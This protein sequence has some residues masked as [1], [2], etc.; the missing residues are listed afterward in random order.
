MEAY[1]P[2]LIIISQ[3]IVF[4]KLDNLLHIV[5]NLIIT[6]FKRTK[7]NNLYRT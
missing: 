4:G 3:K 5:G 7:K 2:E 1:D 6:I